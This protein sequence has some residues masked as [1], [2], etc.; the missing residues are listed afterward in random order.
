LTEPIQ[1]LTL[2]QD[3]RAPSGYIT[4]RLT[5]D[6]EASLEWTGAGFLEPAASTGSMQRTDAGVLRRLFFGYNPTSLCFRVEASAAIGPYDVSLFLRLDPDGAEQ[7]VFPALGEEFP[8]TPFGAN[9]RIDLVPGFGAVLK[10]A[11]ER[12]SWLELDAALESV[13][14]ERAW[15]VRLPLSALGLRLEGEVRVAAALAHEGHIIEAI[16]SDT[17]QTFTLLE[18]T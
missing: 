8:P 4:P 6:N 10:R 13:A 15:E 18:V 12:G 2:R 17:T 16:P 9:W 3:Y 5:G 7:L 11:S 1:G 14:G